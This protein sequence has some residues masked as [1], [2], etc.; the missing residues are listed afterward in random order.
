[1]QTNVS[2]QFLYRCATGMIDENAN[3][4]IMADEMGLGK[5][6]LSHFE[7]SS[8]LLLTISSYNASL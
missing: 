3:G 1:L 7:E 5:T 8:G 6:V 4:S 2:P